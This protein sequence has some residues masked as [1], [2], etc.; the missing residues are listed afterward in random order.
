MPRWSLARRAAALGCALT[1]S[2]GLVPAPAF[3]ALLPQSIEDVTPS[4]DWYDYSQSTFTL[5]DLADFKGFANLVN[6][7][8]DVDGDGVVEPADEFCGAEV[9][10]E[11]DGNPVNFQGTMDPIGSREHPFDG[12]FDGNGVTFDN[13]T[14]LGSAERASDL[15]LFGHAGPNSLIQN[16]TLG[17]ACELRVELG[18][19]SDRTKDNDVRI[20]DVGMLVGSIEGSIANVITEADMTVTHDMDQIPKLYFPIRNV[21][22]IAGSVLGSLT[23]CTATRNASLYVAETGS[24]Y[25]PSSSAEDWDDQA[26]LVLCVGGLVGQAGEIDSSKTKLLKDEADRAGTTF[27]GYEGDRPAEYGTVMDC[28]NASRIDVITPQTNGEDRFGNTVYSQAADVGGIAGYARCSFVGCVNTGFI[29]G[30]HTTGMGGIV[31]NLRCQTET[32]GYNG[33]FT[34]TGY[35]DGI[36]AQKKEGDADDERSGEVYEWS[37][38]NSALVVKDCVNTGNLYGYAFPAGIVGRA[39]TYVDIEGCI[40]GS[41]T[42]EV[43]VVATR[44]TKPFGSGIAGSIKGSVSYCANYASVYS[45]DWKNEEG[46]VVSL[47]GGYYTSGLVGNTIYYTKPNADGDQER[48]TPLPEVRACFSGG[49]VKALDNMRQRLLVGDNAGYVHHNVGLEGLCFKDYLVYGMYDGDTESSGGTWD[50]LFAVSEDVLKEGSEVKDSGGLSALGI[51]NAQAARDGYEYYWVLDHD[52]D[53]PLND[54]YP[55]LNTQL[56][57]SFA[58]MDIAG[59]QVELAANAKYNGSAAIP[60]AKVTLNGATLTQN[61]DFKVIPDSNESIELSE[62][63]VYTA[64]IQGMGAYQGTATAKLR[65]G[66]SKGDLAQCNVTVSSRVFNWNSQKPEAK[67]VV[68]KDPAG[69]TVDSSEYTYDFN[70]ADKQLTDG[71]AVNVGRY[72]VVLKA[73]E[74]A[75]KH[76]TGTAKGTFSIRTCKIGVD[77]DPKKQEQLAKPEGV[78]YLGKE[79]EWDSKTRAIEQ[80]DY[81]PKMVVPYTGKSIKPTIT[82]VTYKGKELQ[83]GVDYQTLYGDDSIMDGTTDDTPN[84]GKKGGKAT[85]YVNCRYVS[86]GNFSNYDIM[87]FTISDEQGV[88]EDKHD[89]TK[90]ELKGTDDV[91]FEPGEPY[92]PVTVWYGGSQLDEGVDYAISY[93]NNAAVGTATFTVT[94]KGDYAGTLTGSFQIVNGAPY[95]LIYDYDETAGTAT[96]TGVEYKGMR[97]SFALTIPSTVKKDDVTYQVTAIASMAFGGASAA[98]F[99]GTAAKESKG[100]INAVTI[101]A[102]VTTIGDYAFA[103]GSSAATWNKVAKVAIANIGSSQLKTIGKYAFSGCGNMTSFT[104]PAKLETIGDG[105]FRTGTVSGTV[106]ESK[107]KRLVFLGKDAGAPAVTGKFTFQGLGSAGSKVLVLGYSAATGVK[108]MAAANAA[109]TKGSN[110]GMNFSYVNVGTGSVAS[111]KYGS[112]TDKTYTGKAQVPAVKVSYGAYTLVKGT[113]YDV[114]YSG[115][116]YVG[117]AKVKVTG[118]GI[119]ASTKTLT[120][121]INPKGTSLTTLKKGKKSLTAYWKK[122]SSQTSGYQIRYS[123]YKSMAKAK[124]VSTTK[125]Y[126]KVTKLKSKKTYYVQV[127]TYKTVSGKKYYS[128]WSAKKSVKTA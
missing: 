123:L 6:G 77:T 29:S 25:K 71:K 22:G 58:R 66:I 41:A 112:L 57:P 121:K 89:I 37:G 113:D 80:K 122:Q 79:Y 5:K 53:D 46:G 68:V 33:N 126:K 91:I 15:G 24:P 110:S 69:N 70:P 82:K 35:D 118:K 44:S 100:R 101:P 73:A 56:S 97:D 14:I 116:K 72:Q 114:S 61:V 109:K 98:D 39:G 86:G 18:S 21:G 63:P 99:R 76:F 87:L 26:V 48:Y 127:R 60:R 19:E 128:A 4:Y 84:M 16:L 42:K 81:E 96:A 31:G 78:R 88:H 1:L 103:S 95:E 90:A 115:N 117:T 92:K 111:C 2:A 10:F 43:S 34:S 65:Y 105:A 8:A 125:T 75:G 94:G 64:T 83:F 20:S 67:D 102:T 36:L 120:F 12:T 45:G 106:V 3:A 47:K 55:V 40:N 93:K 32:T 17:S 38:K 11:N 52:Q 9:Y 28:T 62:D 30:A 74:G 108:S 59:A 27:K 7:V 119:F 51:L 104:F 85:G 54:G 107:I 13:V 49:A 124:T 23:Q 50:N